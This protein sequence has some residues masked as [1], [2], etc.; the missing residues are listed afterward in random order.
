MKGFLFL[1]SLSAMTL[2]VS[3]GERISS[4]NSKRVTRIT[5]QQ[6]RAVMSNQFID[7][8]SINGSSCPEGVARLLILNKQNADKSSVCSGFMIGSDILITNEHCI[9]AQSVCKN[10]HI[11]IYNGHSYEKTKCKSVIKTLNDIK[12]PKDPRKK[13]DVA[14]IQTENEFTGKSFRLAT[15]KPKVYEE[16][17]AWV[18]DHTGLDA[19][20]PN[21]FESR[22]TELKCRVA[23]RPGMSSL[24][25]EKCPVIKGNSGSPLLNAEGEIVGVIW[26]GTAA[27]LKSSVE[28]S[29]RRSISLEAAATEVQHFKEFIP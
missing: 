15:R 22:I 11:A 16:L 24:I 23:W 29:E 2:A 10:T 25:L 14:I 18:V 5:D 8:E 9:P 27:S 19:K 4:S 13:L 20:D 3:C 7:C 28:L 17:T 21:L 12:N 26:G 1:F 6:I